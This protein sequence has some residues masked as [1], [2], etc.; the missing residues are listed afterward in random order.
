MALPEGIKYTGSTSYFGG[1]M[2]QGFE[3]G[4]K[5][6]TAVVKQGETTD[7][8]VQRVLDS[9]Q[10]E[11]I[12]AD[13]TTGLVGPQNQPI[14]D[15]AKQIGPNTTTMSLN[16]NGLAV[17]RV[18]FGSTPI[19]SGNTAPQSD[20]SLRV[21]S[22]KPTPAPA[23]STASYTTPASASNNPYSF[24]N[25]YA[26]HPN[27]NPA[28]SASGTDAAGS[29]FTPIEA[30]PQQ[31]AVSDLLAK[32]RDMQTSLIGKSADTTAAEQAA[33]LDSLR[34]KLADY[35]GKM[36]TL[37]AEAAAIPIQQQE[38]ADGRGITTAM[39]GRQ[40]EKLLNQNAIQQLQVAASI[41][42]TNGMI[43]AAEDKVKRAID[44]KYAP[45]QEQIDAALAN[46]DLLMK[47]PMTTIAEKNQLLKQQAVQAQKQ[48]VIDAAAKKDEL[49]ATFALSQLAMFPTAKIDLSKNPTPSEVVLATTKTS[50]YK[51]KVQAAVNATKTEAQR[52]FELAQS[53]PKFAASLVASD[54]GKIMDAF[55]KDERVQQFQTVNAAYSRINQLRGMD[56]NRDNVN[57]DAMGNN[58]SAVETILTQ[59]ARNEKPD[60]ARAADNGDPTQSQ[61]LSDMVTLRIA[62]LANDKDALASQ[63]KETVFTTDDLYRSAVALKVQAE[64]DFQS[65]FNVPAPV[66]T[67]EPQ[68]YD[69]TVSNPYAK[70]VANNSQGIIPTANAGS[71]PATNFLGF[72][73]SGFYNPSK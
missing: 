17:P 66:L 10:S 3:Y 65:N 41:D 70:P 56:V 67:G 68:G 58:K 28:S 11:A 32:V 45:V 47:D 57:W 14:Q 48:G 31:T 46:I 61:A 33:G 73:I 54:P 25:Y 38:S 8:A 51:L 12:N 4:G 27:A 30:T 55:N 37:Q 62:Q 59:W 44:A 36:M 64:K 16:S 19:N 49:Y 22:P 69:L 35:S 71:S 39:L 18:D 63:L 2:S 53:N 24:A 20:L 7:Q 9:Q 15:W 26:A 6:Y 60:I 13:P 23:I 50:E 21:V 43:S 40:T 5:N 29:T 1:P 52:N 72:D 34:T 42:A